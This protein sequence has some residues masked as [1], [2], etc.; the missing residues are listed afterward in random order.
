[1][2][3]KVPSEF[4]I[5][6]H[7]DVAT[8]EE[9]SSS[10]TLLIISRQGSSFGPIPVIVRAF[11][12]GQYES[13]R[14]SFNSPIGQEAPDLPDDLP[15]P[16][17]ANDDFNSSAQSFVLPDEISLTFVPVRS[18]FVLDDTEAEFT[19]GFVLFLEVAVEELDPRDRNSI[20]V[21]NSLVLINIEDDDRMLITTPLLVSQGLRWS[22][23]HWHFFCVAV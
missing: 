1:M 21:T 8:A 13:F 7:A 9:D 15:D 16:A 22:V 18:L 12:F 14:G 11:T 6:F 4:E 10:E 17:A 19:E 2:P 23:F 3:L 20:T 5:S